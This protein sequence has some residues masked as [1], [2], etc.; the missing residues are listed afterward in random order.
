MMQ[1]TLTM[2]FATR[3]PERLQSC[4]P[5]AF[6]RA[7]L[8][9]ER[10]LCARARASAPF[11]A[12]QERYWGSHLATP[13]VCLPPSWA[14][15][16]SRHFFAHSAPRIGAVFR[17]RSPF[18]PHLRLPCCSSRCNATPFCSWSAILTRSRASPPPFCR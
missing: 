17:V 2:H 7:R 5:T 11:Y 16:S 14:Y 9:T 6:L 1:T 10:K 4:C 13:C 18:A 15:S 8:K 12:P 3:S